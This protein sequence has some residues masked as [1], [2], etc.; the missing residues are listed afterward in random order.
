MV[1]RVDTVVMV[2]GVVVTTCM[3]PVE[4]EGNGLH[5][6]DIFCEIKC[7]T[8]TICVMILYVPCILDLRGRMVNEIRCKLLS[9]VVRFEY[10]KR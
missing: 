6:T 4:T 2:L 10:H 1:D 3:S 7:K 5:V 8:H 9:A